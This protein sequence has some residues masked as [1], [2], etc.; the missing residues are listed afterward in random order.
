MKRSEINAA[1]KR[2][3]QMAAR[4]LFALPP[5]AD[6]TPESWQ[7]KGNE[8]NE[9]RDTMLG[10]D[11]TDYGLG[12]FSKQG[13]SLFTIRNGSF[14][15]SKHKKP[16]AEKLIYLDEG[17][18]CTMHFHWSKM[19]DIICRGGGNLMIKVYNSDKDGL[20]L[21]T[22]VEVFSDGR[23]YT[24]AAGTE[25]RFTPGQ[26]LTITPGLY[27]SFWAEP[28]KGAVLIGEVSQTNDDNTDNRFYEKMNRFSEVEEDEAPYR[29]LCN[30]YPAA[31]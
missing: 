13:I 9:I 6:W 8:Y 18:V 26:S 19:E 25:L 24:V 11:V 27:H 31:K 4:Y 7:Q 22:D 12:D 15:S 10:W 30:E 29:L 28:G 14:A 3:E 2:M 1:I 21:D 20:L 17:Q 5:F 16:Y 23:V